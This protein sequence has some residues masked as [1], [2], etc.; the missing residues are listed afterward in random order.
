MFFKW[1]LIIITTSGREVPQWSSP[2]RQGC[3]DH[4]KGLKEQHGGALP[5][6][7]RARIRK[8]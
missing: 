7:V 5:S 8:I 2:N 6:G 1:E 3:R 4:L